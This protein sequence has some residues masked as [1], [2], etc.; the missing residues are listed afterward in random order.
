MRLTLR[1]LLAYLDDALEPA[2]TKEI[3]RKIQE[4][5]VAQVLV[6]RIKEVMRRRRLGAPDL[7]GPRMGIDPN[8]VAQYLDNTLPPDQVG[9]V[10]KV[11]LESDQQLAEVAACHQ[12]LTIALGEPVEI[13][14]H[15]RERLYVLGPVEAGEKLQ[16]SP[17]P[18]YRGNGEETQKTPVTLPA[19]P[20]AATPATT[21][22]E[23]LPEY[24]RPKPWTG[25]ILAAAAIVVL[26][27]VWIG[28]V[29][30][31]RELVDS[32]M[33][34]RPLPRSPEISPN[35]PDQESQPP[36]VPKAEVAGAEQ[37]EPK[38]AVTPPPVAHQEKAP[39]AEAGD[40][41]AD[42]A[43]VAKVKPAPVEDKPPTPEPPA[44]GAAPPVRPP[45]TV[46]AVSTEGILLTFRPDEKRWYVVPR[47]SELKLGA[48]LACP[49]PFESVLEFDHGAFRA[50]LLGGTVAELLPPT[51]TTSAG[52][53][54]LSGRVILQ[55]TRKDDARWSLGFAIGPRQ[56]VLEF[57]PG[58]TLCGIEFLLGEPTGFEQPVPVT[59]RREGMYV[60]SGGVTWTPDDQ[61]ARGANKRVYLALIS[62]QPPLNFGPPA[63]STPEWLDPQR[64]KVG[65]VLRRFALLF[66]KEFELNEPIDSSM[67]ALIRDSRPKISELAV[68][69]LALTDN[70]MALVQ[71][72][73]QANN[74]D[75]RKAASE[76]LRQWLGVNAARGEVLR[77][78]LASY[79][80]RKDDIEALYRLLW[81][82]SDIEARNSQVSQKV[83]EWLQ[84]EKVEI[85]ELA[86]A[87]AVRL[88][89]RK[90][91]YRPLDPFNRREMAV[92][93]WFEHVQREGALVSDE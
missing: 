45:A 59:S 82:I 78:A 8:I 64:R 92:K 34:L 83:V 91:D 31:D 89:G 62:D 51:E 1:T 6:S 19:L 24:L 13:S 84:N 90:Y 61:P 33:G 88:T 86:F 18:A 26:V 7:E 46:Q 22:E 35:T 42:A 5:P 11:F 77:Q 93:R 53:R 17:E 52:L 12:I 58:E 38:P 14:K 79:Y 70:P 25:K 69:C 23:S 60:L 56:G 2:E 47:Q 28:A 48:W 37:G 16:V 41:P 21:F 85:R 72:L 55:T 27:A 36:E 73:A 68:R 74:D 87:N 50:T 44:E 57:Q 49:E 65:S 32:F 9:E 76:G 10:E 4:S 39:A 71:A 40:E 81:G 54:L 3:G 80:E 15:S 20:P 29:L 63:G 43:L 30:S 67:L 66:E 75:A